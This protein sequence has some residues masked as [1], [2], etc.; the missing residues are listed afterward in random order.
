[1][2][3]V[4]PMASNR[5]VIGKLTLPTYLKILGWVATFIMALATVGMF[6]TTGNA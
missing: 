3:F 5:K 4:M 2:A 1:M 6:L